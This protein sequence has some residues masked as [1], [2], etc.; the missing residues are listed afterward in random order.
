MTPF[1][2]LDGRR[3]LS[4]FY[5]EIADLTAC[6]IPFLAAGLAAGERCL[7][8]ISPPLGRGAAIAALAA[9]LPDLDRRMARGDIEVI[10]HQ[11]WYLAAGGMDTDRVIAAWL[12]Q[13]RQA[14]AAGYRGLR[15]T[16]NTFWLERPE[17]FASFA[18]YEERLHATLTDRRITCL[19]SY[20]LPRCPGTTII[21]VVRNHDCAIVRRHG[22][23]EILE[24]ASIKAEKRQLAEALAA[25]ETLLNEVHHRVKNNLQIVSSLLMLKA[26]EFTEP[27]ARQAMDDTLQRIRAMGLVHEMLYQQGNP[28]AVDFTEYLAT[29]A[30]QMVEAHGMTA[31]VTVA[32]EDRTAPGGAVIP[33]DA[34]IPLGIAAAETLTNALK[35][36]FPDGRRGRIAILVENDGGALRFSVIDDGVGTPTPEPSRR[37]GAGLGLVRGLAAQA[38]G[39]VARIE[40]LTRGFGLRFDLPAF[41]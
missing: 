39:S 14:L 33:L 5:D 37:G 24:N 35:H 41:G 16:G 18:A 30:R 31:T 8:V 4:H 7:W 3:H 11:D 32:V 20:C 22:A 27:A 9:E 26:H 29:L 19:C 40:G 13:E 23:W 6:V 38:G 36:A 34:A 2:R 17:D 10:D 12:D 1:A 21:D 15:I 28:G 25:K